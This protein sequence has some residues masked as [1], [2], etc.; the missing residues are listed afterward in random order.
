MAKN[1]LVFM[2]LINTELCWF[3]L[4]ATGAEIKVNQNVA[5]AA[6]RLTTF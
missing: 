3:S 6:V 5:R 4:V 2:N 1:S